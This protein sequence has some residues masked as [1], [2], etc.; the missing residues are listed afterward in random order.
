MDINKFVD[1]DDYREWLRAPF[2]VDG[3]TC[4]TNGQI[5]LSM[6]QYGNFDDGVES[7]AK[8]VRGI[9]DDMKGVEFKPL[10]SF[11]IPAKEVCNTCKG[12][13]KA[14]REK[15]HECDGDGEV[16]AET[17]YNTYY[18]LECKSCDGRGHTLIR[19]GDE[20]C[21]DCGGLGERY[22]Y[23]VPISVEGMLVDLKYLSLLTG[24]DGVE[25]GKIDGKDILAF[26]SGDQIGVIMGM[27]A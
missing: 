11:E 1:K 10:G 26:R 27:R 3:R 2:N 22:N 14:V 18:G 19:G 15:C 5:F 16:D 6:P 20:N 12:T 25:V 24:E 8:G 7:I 9:L 4:A 23:P 21:P 13:C 17:D